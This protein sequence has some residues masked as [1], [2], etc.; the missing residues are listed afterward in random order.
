MRLHSMS[1]LLSRHPRLF[2]LASLVWL[3]LC[4]LSFAGFDSDAA[5]AQRTRRPARPAAS[6]ATGGTQSNANT[7]AQRPTPPKKRITPLRSTETAEGSSVTI[8]SDAALNDYSAYRSGNKFYVV[9]PQADSASALGAIRGKGF[10]DAQVQ[11]RGNDVVLSFSLQPGASASVNQRFNRLIVNFNA[12]GAASQ[13]NAQNNA[14]RPPTNTNTARPNENTRPNNANTQTPVANTNQATTTA[15]TNQSATPKPGEQFPQELFPNTNTQN[16]SN[17]NQ[18]TPTVDPGVLV[19]VPT[20]TVSPSPNEIAQAMPTPATVVP[21]VAPRSNANQQGGNATGFG[22]MLVRNWWMILIAALLLGVLGLVAFARSGN[23]RDKV[24]TT[25]TAT[26]TTSDRKNLTDKEVSLSSDAAAAAKIEPASQAVTATTPLVAAS[27]LA[28]ES[29]SNAKAGRKKSNAKTLDRKKTDT[30]D[31]KATGVEARDTQPLNAAP[32]AVT[33]ASTSSVLPDAA[34][35]QPLS[36][37]DLAGI[38]DSAATTTLASS[39][40]QTNALDHSDLATTGAV[41]AALAGATLAS[42]LTAR[43][44]KQDP[45]AATQSGVAATDAIES[46]RASASEIINADRAQT[47]VQLL[48][49]GDK[50]DEQVI[51]TRDAGAR[52]IIAAELLAALAGRNAQRKERAKDA[53]F[54]HDYFTDMTR[55]LRDASA[56]AER[57]SAARA[58]GMLGDFRATPELSQAL[59]DKSPDVRR[60]AVEALTDVC[61]P[62]SLR[63]LRNLRD[64]E[65]DRKVPQ[66]LIRRA[67]ETIIASTE[68][69]TAAVSPIA[70]PKVSP[71]VSPPAASV[72]E[73][74]SD[75]SEVGAT[76]LK[77]DTSEASPATISSTET[78]Q[79]VGAVTI[80][81]LSETAVADEQAVA[82]TPESTVLIGDVEYPAVIADPTDATRAE[83]LTPTADDKAIAL[84]PESAATETQIIGDSFSISPALIKDSQ[85]DAKGI[86]VVPPVIE[87][88]SDVG[89]EEVLEDEKVVALTGEAAVTDASRV[90]LPPHETGDW[91]EVDVFEPSI[92]AKV[93]ES[94]NVSVREPLDYSANRFEQPVGNDVTDSEST[95]AASVPLEEVETVF[96]THAESVTVEPQTELPTA[97]GIAQI[98]EIELDDVAKDASPLFVS[99]SDY[100]SDRASEQPS[101]EREEIMPA[102]AE[103]ASPT[104]FVPHGT[105]APTVV[106]ADAAGSIESETLTPDIHATAPNETVAS[107]DVSARILQLENLARSRGA[108]ALPEINKAFDDDAPEVRA[109]AARAL[110]QTNADRTASFTQALREA[111]PDRRRRIGAAIATS[112][113]AEESISQLTGESRDKTY[114]AFSLLF[115]MAKAGEVQPL[116]RAIESHTNTEVRLAVIKLLALSGQ[117]EILPAFRRLAVRGSLPAEVRS[118]IME[119]IY[120]ISNQTT[121]V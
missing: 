13:T 58:L 30:L 89:V 107:E 100:V 86:E 104:A 88:T 68:A 59:K 1:K 84:V 92:S 3:V 79:N 21:P 120:Q 70:P 114:D 51:G 77:L 46:E 18:Q 48:L 57:A 113:L 49:D 40:A 64:R 8:T 90:D 9:I 11:R 4:G 106:S 43:D 15:N 80:A 63:A 20:P 22:A 67:I 87:A 115:L 36:A 108:N 119:A 110:D 24:V 32:G 47:E 103:S 44:S 28:S 31:T 33:S 91:V 60:A 97:S 54:A 2:V 41:T 111:S 39:G 75:A 78:L 73:E 38:E 116:L 74:I 55:D 62:A 93:A 112:G 7:P 72:S 34:A 94:A 42:G 16:P 69:T 99:D 23:R 19:G 6:P 53:Y 61:D 71:I 37:S 95:R 105:F 65:R 25:R 81:D 52:Q 118:S 96:E 83:A 76:T 50:Y 35:T 56:P 27:G 5:H 85:A 10:N 98:K 45:L 117:Q 14:N 17:T 29:V 26:K 66:K 12:P 82:H 101:L 121:T 102:L 109:A